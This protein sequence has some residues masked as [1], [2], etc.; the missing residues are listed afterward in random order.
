MQKEVGYG[1]VKVKMLCRGYVVES[2]GFA[3]R[4]KCKGDVILGEKGDDGLNVRIGER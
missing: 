2:E 4:G 3:I 1:V